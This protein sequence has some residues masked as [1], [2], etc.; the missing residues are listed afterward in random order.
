LLASKHQVGGVFGL[1]DAPVPIFLGEH[2]GNRAQPVS[3]AGE[4]S[5]ELFGIEGVGRRLSSSNVGY[6]QE[7]VVFLHAVDAFAPE[8]ACQGNV[9][10]AVELQSEWRPGRHA[11]IAQ[12]ELLVDEVEVVM[13]GLPVSPR[14]KT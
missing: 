3:V 13:Q 7:G 5:V 9:T 12:T 1:A 6:A 10:I 11:Q 4:A 2:I 8:R 14:G